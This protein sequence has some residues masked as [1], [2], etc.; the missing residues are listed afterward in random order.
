MTKILL[1]KPTTQGVS[2]GG[3]SNNP[4][5]PI[6]YLILSLLPFL[7]AFHLYIRHWISM[8]PLPP[9]N[10]KKWGS[11][12]EATYQNRKGMDGIGSNCKTESIDTN[13]F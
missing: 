1:L 10:G 6:H 3:R 9:Q 5:P 2:F 8:D 11:N 4:P 7:H 13:S 12:G